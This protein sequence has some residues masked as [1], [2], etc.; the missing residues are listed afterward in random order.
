MKFIKYL[1]SNFLPP[2]LVQV[3]RGLR[4]NVERAKLK[5][6]S[7]RGSAAYWTSHM[8]AHEDWLDAEDSLE[9]FLWRNSQYPLYI[10]L[11]PVQGADALV[12]MDYGCGPGNDLVGFHEF[13]KPVRLI[14]ADVSKAAL[15]VSRRRLELHK[16]DIEL[17]LI[18][19]D[20]NRIK[21]SDGTLDLVHSSGVLHHVKHIEV[22]LKEIQRVMKPGGKFQVMVYNYDS[23]WL[24]LITAYVHQIELGV[25]SELSLLEAFRRTTDGPECPI[26]HCY[27]PSEFLQMVCS[28]G[29]SGKF[30]GSSMSNT[31]LEL[32]HKRFDAL[33]SRKLKIEHRDFLSSLT[34][35]ERGHPLYKGNV[36]GINACYEFIKL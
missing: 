9:H 7:H 25:D 13:S 4:D 28:V 19:E 8:V 14:G 35:D 27:R 18:D 30:K 32:M 2:A 33:K 5:V 22:A 17:I 12:V 11:M 6:A 29:F 26:S 21:V 3:L 16:A 20:S 23:L 34:F 36:A 15:S 31:E 1:V 10:D 24:H